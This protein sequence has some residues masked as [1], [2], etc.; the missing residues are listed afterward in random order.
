MTPCFLRYLLLILAVPG[1]IYAQTAAV[2]VA[3]YAVTGEVAQTRVDVVIGQTNLRSLSYGQSTDVAVAAGPTVL[4]RASVSGSVEVLVESELAI[5]PGERYLLLLSGD[6]ERHPYR[7]QLVEDDSGVID[8]Q[9]RGLLVNVGFLPFGPGDRGVRWLLDSVPELPLVDLE[10]GEFAPLVSLPLLGPVAN[11]TDLVVRRLDNGQ[12]L[13]DTR[14]HLVDDER[15]ILLFSGDSAGAGV[16][17]DMI[18]AEAS[19]RSSLDPLELGPVEV[20]LVHGASFVGGDS[21]PGDA[22]LSADL[23]SVA[24]VAYAA[25]SPPVILPEQGSHRFGATSVD[26]LDRAVFQTLELEGNRSYLVV[27]KSFSSEADSALFSDPEPF[28]AIEI[29][30]FASSTLSVLSLHYVPSLLPMDPLLKVAVRSDAGEVQA[31]LSAQPGLRDFRLQSG[32]AIRADLKIS[33]LDGKRNFLDIAPVAVPS[34]TFVSAVI[35]GNGSNFPFRL[36]SSF[37][38][39]TSEPLV[40]RAVS[41]LWTTVGRPNQG[42][43]FSPLPEEDRLVGS[44]FSY[45]EQGGG[46]RWFIVDSCNSPAG[47]S[48][49]STAAA[50][51]NSQALLT[52]YTA[53]GG[54]FAGAP[55]QLSV[56][57]SMAIEFGGCELAEVSYDLAEFGSGSFQIANLTPSEDCAPTER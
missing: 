18:G 16:V 35:V 50:F 36:V 5:E 39:L 29:D 49:C 51:N 54:S 43:S 15:I 19:G 45:A 8:G 4:A 11:Q 26:D 9:A 24:R 3:P 27:A 44:W 55:P 37:A 48:G 12:T 10:Y 21:E 13:V 53:S 1:V 31:E 14:S 42:F 28:V 34:G 17:M 25:V 22:F 23:S 46:Q 56:A 20:Q 6:G 41:G 2:V 57:G 38:G 52:V 7:L 47:M 32:S 40:D 30:R 33:S